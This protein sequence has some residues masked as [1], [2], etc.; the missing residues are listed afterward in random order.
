MRMHVHR[1]ARRSK[2]HGATVT[3]MHRPHRHSIAIAPFRHDFDQRICI[4]A[5]HGV[6]ET[7]GAVARN[8]SFLHRAVAGPWSAH[9]RVRRSSAIGCRPIPVGKRTIDSN[10]AP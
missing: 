7:A 8:R 10:A 9:R 3:R 6:H 5:I 4:G 2:R 1:H